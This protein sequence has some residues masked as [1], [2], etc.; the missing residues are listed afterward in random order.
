MKLLKSN[1]GR[2]GAL[3]L[4]LALALIPLSTG[5]ASANTTPGWGDDKPDVIWDCNN[6]KADSCQYHETNAWTSLGKRRQVGNPVNNC[7]GSTPLGFDLTFR[8]D[9][10]TEYSFQQ[11][12]KVE[13]SAGFSDVLTGGMSASST[14]TETWKAGTVTS[15]G[16]TLKGTIPAH[17][18]GGYWFAPYER[19]SQGWVEVHYG[20]RKNG[21]Y[22]WYY[23]GQGSTGVQINTPVKLS[24]GSMKGQWYWATWK[25]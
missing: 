5:T 2:F 10:S 25:C 8:T 19:H 7:A 12:T 20:K 4:A 17:E 15:A 16:T 3:A 23:P 14:Q 11:E 18:A 24:D 6:G 1:R 21:H 9:R 22:F 13:V